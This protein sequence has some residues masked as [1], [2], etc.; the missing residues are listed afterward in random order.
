MGGGTGRVRARRIFLTPLPERAVGTGRK[1]QIAS[2]AKNSGLASCRGGSRG[3]NSAC[4]AS[5]QRVR[6]EGWSVPREM[7]APAPSRDISVHPRCGLRVIPSKISPVHQF[8]PFEGGLSPSRVP[9][10]VFGLKWCRPSSCLS[11][12]RG[13]LTARS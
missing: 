2:P 10:G 5:F 13:Q 9:E 3:V 6:G 4:R 1:C 7:R 11:P 8:P 12:A